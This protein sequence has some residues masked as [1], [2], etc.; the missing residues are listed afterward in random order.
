MSIAT[1]I[2]DRFFRSRHQTDSDKFISV[3]ESGRARLDLA[4][5]LRSDKGQKRVEAEAKKI[6]EVA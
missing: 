5:Y 2:I 1:L 3:D 6:N 4:A